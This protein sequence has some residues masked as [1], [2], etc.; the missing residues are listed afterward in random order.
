[1][2]IECNDNEILLWIGYGN[3]IFTNP[4]KTDN[5]SQSYYDA[6]C[7]VGLEYNKLEKENKELRIK[8]RNHTLGTIPIIMNVIAGVLSLSYIIYSLLP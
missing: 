7:A 6:L 5:E 8:N 2:K 3:T 1:M 4:R